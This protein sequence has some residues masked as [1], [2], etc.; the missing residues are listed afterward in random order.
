MTLQD[1]NGINAY[2]K[3]K[4]NKYN[5]NQND[6]KEQKTNQKSKKQSAKL[7]TQSRKETKEK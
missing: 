4:K 3:I 5:D 7:K 2:T 6:A 1:K